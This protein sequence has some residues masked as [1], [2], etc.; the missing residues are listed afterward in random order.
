MLGAFMAGILINRVNR[1]AVLTG[2]MVFNLWALVWL[3]MHKPM[4]GQFY[5]YYMMSMLLGF[6]DA[7]RLVVLQCK[8]L[9]HCWRTC[10]GSL[11]YDDIEYMTAPAYY[12]LMFAGSE[13]LA[14]SNFRLYETI[15]RV[16]NFAMSPRVCTDTQIALIGIGLVFGMWGFGA[17]EHLRLKELASEMDWMEKHTHFGLSQL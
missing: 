11:L 2:L 16:L 4:P 6:I 13:A 14:F 10:C 12:G 3:Y 8:W 1:V 17:A 15:G 9:T 7:I 5:A